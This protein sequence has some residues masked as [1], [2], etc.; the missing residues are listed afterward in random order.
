LIV[1][2][3]DAGTEFD[4]GV[5]FDR[6]VDN[7]M[8]RGY[9]GVVDDLFAPLRRVAVER[10]ARLTPPAASRVPFVV[11][12]A[13]K[14][15]PPT[16]TM[17]QTAL[18]GRSR[19]GFV[20]RSYPEG[21][22]DRFEPIPDLGVPAED[23]YLAFDVDRGEETLDVRP[24]DAML[25]VAGQGRSPLTIEEGIALITHFPGILEKNRCFSLGGSRCG[26]RRVPALWISKGAPKLGWCWG[27]NPHTWLGLACCAQRRGAEQ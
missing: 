27:G 5:E 15:A 24:D 3:L 6:Q 12:L 26:D 1:T 19:P 23:A 21:D 20:D 8:S 10:S 4:A 7:L 2:G 14:L 11:V 22:L 18:A 13:R 9:P 16:L 25:T 17:P